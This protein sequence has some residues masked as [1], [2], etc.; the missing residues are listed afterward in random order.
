MANKTKAD[1]NAHQRR[2]VRYERLKRIDCLLRSESGCTITEIC[3]DPEIDDVGERTIR[4]D[5]RIL[6]EK[7]NVKWANLPYRGRQKVWRYADTN[8]SINPQCDK[9]IVHKAI[10]ILGELK[11]DPRYNMIRHYLISLEKEPVNPSHF[12]NMISFDYCNEVKGLEFVEELLDAITNKQPLRMTYKSFGGS[13]TELKFHP[14]HLRQYNRRWFVF[15]FVEEHGEMRNY[16]LDRIRDIR[17]LCKQYKETD[18]DFSD[19]FN[20]I[21]GVTNPKSRE[22]EK[23]II[24]VSDKSYNYIRTKPFHHSQRELTSRKTDE[25]AYF[26]LEVKVNRELEMQLFSYIDAIEVVEPLWLRDKFIGYIESLHN[27]YNGK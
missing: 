15:G 11:G 16:A 3:T 9:E 23:I 19:Y 26:S 10:E 21:V 2:S 18:I 14:W 22:V 4:D 24:K 17:P 1:E 25:F 12:M 6:V 7:Y 27:K 5:L 13:V 8:F 20:E